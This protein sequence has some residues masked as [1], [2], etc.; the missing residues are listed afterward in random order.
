MGTSCPSG[1]AICTQ[2]QDSSLGQQ[3]HM[4]TI[5][6]IDKL[7]L[8]FTYCMGKLCLE[9]LKT[10]TSAEGYVHSHM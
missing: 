1:S 3:R 4:C 10:C 9:S 7:K 5:T 8:M 2:P 6:H